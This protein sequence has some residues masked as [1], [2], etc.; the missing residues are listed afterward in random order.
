MIQRIFRPL[1]VHKRSEIRYT[2]MEML[3]RYEI[4]YIF[5]MNS[6]CDSQNIKKY[7]WLEK[8]LKLKYMLCCFQSEVWFH[9][10]CLS[11]MRGEYF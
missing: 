11:W 1:L 3:E 4:H 9:G 2:R 8:I 7:F 5:I 6:L 10:D